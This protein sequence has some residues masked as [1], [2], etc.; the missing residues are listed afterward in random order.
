VNAHA[1]PA[2]VLIGGAG[3]AGCALA[4]L[5]ARRGLP[6]WIVDASPGGVRRLEL[7][8]PSGVRLLEAVGIA[9]LLE[10]R[11]L[12]RPCPGIRR[13]L[14]SGRVEVD[15]FL[16]HPGGRGFLVDRARFDALVHGCATNAGAHWIRARVVTATRREGHIVCRLSDGAEV[17]AKVA[18][19]ATGRPA[20]VARRLG[21]TRLVHERLIAS[22]E[23]RGAVEEPSAWLEVD[24]GVASWSY[25]LTGPDGIHERW[26]VAH[27]LPKGGARANA[28][29]VRLACAAGE[30]WIAIG[31]AAAAFDPVASQGLANAF[32]TALAAA[33]ILSSP[34]GLSDASGRRYADRV[35]ATFDHSERVRRAIYPGRKGG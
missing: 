2:P 12:A 14:P 5:L 30:G 3:P 35:A 18:V 10:D 1:C 4:A 23:W 25:S 15:D 16:R 29:S 19:D 24:W 9:H 32:S 17:A 21:A 27:H 28:S 8:A 26:Q 22:C 33:E 20:A 34:Q 31:D 7:V 11:T 13:R 6:A